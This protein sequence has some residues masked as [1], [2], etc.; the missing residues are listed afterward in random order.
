M[1]PKNSI[2]LI[3]SQSWIPYR[4]WDSG[5]SGIPVF[6]V[7]C[8][9]N[10]LLYILLYIFFLYILKPPPPPHFHPSLA[11]PSGLRE[12]SKPQLTTLHDFL[13]ILGY[14]VN[15]SPVILSS[16]SPPLLVNLKISCPL[17]NLMCL[18]LIHCSLQKSWKS[19]IKIRKVK[20]KGMT[21]IYNVW[22][23]LCCYINIVPY[24]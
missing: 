9:W 14:G 20:N 13:S 12:F 15:V 24:S 4:Y 18:F 23:S 3:I 10:I 11:Q 22:C 21:L 19:F 2:I 5:I 1:E 16:W 7:Q 17:L 6:Q 8:I